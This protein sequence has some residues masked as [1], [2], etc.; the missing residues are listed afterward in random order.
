M[1]PADPFATQ[2]PP[3]NLQPVE[4]D[5]D[6]AQAAATALREAAA[7]LADSSAQSTVGD[8][9]RRLRDVADALRDRADTA[10]TENARRAAVLARLQKDLETA[11][12]HY[13]ETHVRLA[14]RG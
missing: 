2:G 7:R 13:S 5:F 12:R 1:P 14:R 9:V 4:F 11:R 10:R 8:L 3:A 6:A